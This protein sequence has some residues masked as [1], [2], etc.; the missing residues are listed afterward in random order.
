MVNGVLHDATIDNNG[1]HI[2]DPSLPQG[3]N[4]QLQQTFDLATNQ[5]GIDIKLV[6]PSELVTGAAGDASIG[7]LLVSFSATAPVVQVPTEVARAVAT[8]FNALN[9]TVPGGTTKC[10]TDVEQL[11][12]PAGSSLPSLPLCFGLGALPGFGSQAVLT[13]TLGSAEAY[14]AGSLG[15]IPPAV[16]AGCG[17]ACSGGGFTPP[18]FVQPPAVTPIAGNGSFGTAPPVQPQATGPLLGVYA[19][20]PSGVLMGIGVALLM[21]AVGAALGPSLRHARDS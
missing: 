12:G 8:V 19:R 3:Q 13:L 6:S 4:A 20:M 16:G 2:Q 18:P 11:L 1:V 9:Q 21:L 5:L 15:Y 7:G 17:A 14:S 10:L